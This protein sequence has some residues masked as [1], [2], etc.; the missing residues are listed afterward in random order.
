MLTLLVLIASLFGT[1]VVAAYP[2]RAA[3]GANSLLFDDFTHDTSLNA[4]LW[5]ANGTVGSVFGPDECG[6]CELIPLVPT[7]SSAGMEIAQANGKFEVGTIQSIESFTPP[8]TANAVVEGTVSNGHTF[9]F[10]ISSANASSGVL[11][12]GNLNPTNCSHLGDC[13]DPTVCGTP[14][15]SA[16]PP[17]QCYYG[18]DA[19]TG[20]GGGSWAGKMKLYPTPSVNISYMLQ[21]SVDA[22]GSAQFSVSQGGQVLGQSTAQI[23]TGPF[24]IIIEQAEGAPVASPG[25]NQ[26]YWM[27]VGL[28]SG[29]TSSTTTSTLPSPVPAPAGL[30]WFVWIIIVIALGAL[31]FFILLWYRRRGF[32]VKVL[33]SQ[34][35]SPIPKASVVARGPEK[36]SGI[37]GNDGKAAFGSVDEGDYSIG[38]TAAGYNPS[39]PVT[40]KVKKRT[41]Y[42]ARLDRTEPGAR[43]GVVGNAPSEGQNREAVGPDEGGASSRNAGVMVPSSGLETRQ[44]QTAVAQPPQE[45]I[46]PVM[47]R[48]ESES[49]PSE[50]QGLELEG[51][52]GGRIRQI[53]KTFQDKGAISPETAQTAEELGLSRLFVRIL[54]RRRGKTRVFIEINGRYY[55]NQKALQEMQ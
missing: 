13:S 44:P 16:I 46:P 45:G 47:T 28:T 37:T 1:L 7:F 53:I 5:Q 52:G 36:L 21:I 33:D 3:S 29:T 54:K 11:I 22:S 39:T 38:V 55:L 2:T 30:P 26:A 49:P 23:G 41:E 15:N 9:G 40:I 12:Y 14:A 48:P 31:F 35:Q 27:S 24:Y 51:W 34:T 17:N 20:Q 6:P 42:T 25:P 50:W 19:K 10:A 43:R 8:F 4:G 18:I 32:T